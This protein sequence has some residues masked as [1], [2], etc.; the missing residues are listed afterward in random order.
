MTSPHDLMASCLIEGFEVPK[1]AAGPMFP[2]EDEWEMVAW[3]EYGAMEEVGLT[4]SQGAPMGLLALEKEMEANLAAEKGIEDVLL[5]E[6]DRHRPTKVITREMTV[7]L[8]A[9]ILGGTP[10][11]FDARTDGRSMKTILSHIAPRKCIIIHGLEEERAALSAA[12]RRELEGLQSVVY[13]PL[14]DGKPLEIAVESSHEV[15]LHEDLLAGVNM[16]DLGECRIGWVGG[17]LQCCADESSELPMLVRQSTLADNTYQYGGIFIGDVRLS[18]LKKAL[19]AAG[20]SAHF[21]GGAL[22]CAGKVVVKRK[23]GQSAGLQVEGALS[24]EYYKVR[25]IAY[26]LYHIA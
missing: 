14:D 15:L 19:E 4:D 10:Y 17:A 2:A 22:H 6:E 24:N 16:H 12:L 7:M 26:G 9:R 13:G 3:D 18:E 1:G 21:H 11:Y 8:R 25:D 23:Q 20:V 5:H